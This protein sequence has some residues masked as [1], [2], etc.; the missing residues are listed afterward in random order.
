MTEGLQIWN[1]SGKLILDATHRCG[2]V[3]DIIQL[4]GGQSGSQEYPIF[5]TGTPFWAYQRDKTFH[6]SYGYGGLISPVIS[7]SGNVLSWKYSAKQA[8]YDEYAAGFII[9]GVF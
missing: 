5:S 7:R 1:E 2:R 9:V 6:T 4:T 8:S 3:V